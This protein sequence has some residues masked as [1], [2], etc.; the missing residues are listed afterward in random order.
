[1]LKINKL[2]ETGFDTFIIEKVF[3]KQIEK[4]VEK[5][6]WIELEQTNTNTIKAAPK[7]MY[8]NVDT[9]M[10]NS[11][12]QTYSEGNHEHCE[13]FKKY[14]NIFTQMLKSTKYNGF[15]HMHYTLEINTIQLWDGVEEHPL[16]HWDGKVNGDLFFLLYL[17]DHDTWD[18][19]L[20][21]GLMGGTRE[22]SDKP[23]W[24]TD[25]LKEED[26]KESEIFYP[27]NGRI[28]YGNNT[29]PRQIH[30]PIAISKK[31]KEENVRRTTF[32]VTIKLVPK[33]NY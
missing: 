23:S 15:L 26:L 5:E 18:K 12:N 11:G 9:S 27:D 24:E 19:E 20:G 8:D 28:V 17:S 4:L 22:L 16:L 2:Y 6:T 10:D 14:K 3:L 7:W 29:N 21:G 25:N 13:E 33:K 32:L 31:G 30:K 1:M